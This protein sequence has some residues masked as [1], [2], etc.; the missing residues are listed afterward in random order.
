MTVSVTILNLDTVVQQISDYSK[1]LNGKSKKLVSELC[2]TGE[3]E[4]TMN[5]TS[6]GAFMVGDLM[7]GIGSQCS[8]KK[9]TVYCDSSHAVFVEFGTG[10]AHWADY[11]HPLRSNYGFEPGSYG[12][13]NGASP[14]GWWY[15][16][17]IDKLD[18]LQDYGARMMTL[19]DGRILAHTYGMPSRPFMY[20]AS[21]SMRNEIHKTARRIF[22]S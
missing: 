8:G 14:G 19:D 20:N 22:K 6:M 7:A 3:A 5:A 15:P 13:G 4:A 21:Q 11:D 16:V 18:A 9:G 1:S 17:D 2:K 12:K 10:V